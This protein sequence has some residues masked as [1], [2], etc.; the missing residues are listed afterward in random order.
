MQSAR[1]VINHVTDGLK[2]ADK[3]KL[4]QVIRDFISEHHGRGVAKYFYNTYCQTHPDEE[5]DPAPFTYPGPNPRSRETSLLMMADAV[6]AASRSLKDHSAQAISDLVNRI[7]DQQ[8]ADGLH[9]DSPLS[10][11]DIKM[12]KDIFTQRLR[13]LYHSRVSYPE[14]VKPKDASAPSDTNTD[15]STTTPPSAK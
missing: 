14:A 10:F 13:T 8:I 4:P 9:N 5:V 2:L 12:V 6:E 7:I 15:E 1:I 11:R 3:H